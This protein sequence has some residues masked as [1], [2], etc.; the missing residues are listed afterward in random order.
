MAVLSV[1]PTFEG[2]DGQPVGP[3]DSLM[4]SRMWKITTDDVNETESAIYA[5]AKPGGSGIAGVSGSL[6]AYLGPHPENL[7]FTCRSLV[8]EPLKAKYAW[9]ARASYSA[10]P[11]SKEERDRQTHPNPVD[12]PVRIQKKP[13]EFVSHRTKTRGG[14]PIVN[15]AEDPYPA[16]P[17]EDSRTV[18]IVE[19]EVSTW[20]DEWDDLDNSVNQHEFRMTDGIK[21]VTIPA[22]RGLMKPLSVS[23]RKEEN[24]FSYYTV[25]SEIH[26]FKT[27]DDL[28]LELLDEGFHYID[29]STKKRILIKD[30]SGRDIVPAEAQLLDGA[31]GV[32]AVGGTPQYRTFDDWRD[33]VAWGSVQCPFGV[34]VAA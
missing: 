1:R 23:F 33:V 14:T 8:I 26:K 25:T 28:K 10:A 18:Y 4:K 21:V 34:E 9:I 7:F 24:G 30:A 6:P 29:G 19:K 17:F 27:V 22:R 5:Q 16:Q 12:R 15:S 20:L 11:I 31:G 13:V 3:L 32:L 2:R